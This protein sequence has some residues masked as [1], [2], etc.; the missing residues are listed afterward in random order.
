MKKRVLYTKKTMFY[1]CFTILLRPRRFIFV[2]FAP[3]RQWKKGRKESLLSVQNFQKRR[4]TIE[5]H[6]SVKNGRF[7]PSRSGDDSRKRG[8]KG[9]KW[10]TKGGFVQLFSRFFAFFLAFLSTPNFQ[11]STPFENLACSKTRET[12]QK[13]RKKLHKTTR[14]VPFSTLPPAF[15]KLLVRRKR[16]KTVQN[17]HFS[18]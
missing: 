11:K 14:F 3:L 4:F 16:P 13:T 18:L 5:T 15:P 10:H 1:F 6:F 7:G 8:R 9:P 2:N 17:A 12:S